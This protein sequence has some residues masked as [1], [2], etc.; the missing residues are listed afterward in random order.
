M[1]GYKK[2]KTK[3]RST[4]GCWAEHVNAE[5]QDLLN[6][7][8][9]RLHCLIKLY[10]PLFESYI[11]FTWM[12]TC[13]VRN[14]V[15]LSFS[16]ILHALDQKTIFLFSPSSFFHIQVISLHLGFLAS[17][18]L[19]AITYLVP[20]S[21][22]IKFRIAPNSTFQGQWRACLISTEAKSNKFE[23]SQSQLFSILIQQP[24]YIYGLSKTNQKCIYYI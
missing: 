13:F 8:N 21:S 12:N 22:Y 16:M 15:P 1:L 24:T 11:Y 10:I 19:T 5:V 3:Y 17:V 7:A 9:A 23:R 20:A 2:Q 14:L 18:M 6:N 4:S